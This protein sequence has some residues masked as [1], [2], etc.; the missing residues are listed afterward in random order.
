MVLILV[1]ILSFLSYQYHHFHH[2]HHYYG[3][4]YYYFKILVNNNIKGYFLLQVSE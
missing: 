4:K 2:F 1:I 3:I